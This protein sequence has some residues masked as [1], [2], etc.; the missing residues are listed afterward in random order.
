MEERIIKGRPSKQAPQRRI[1][2]AKTGYDPLT[3]SPC[4]VEDS[5]WITNTPP[6]SPHHPTP[7][8][9]E[10]NHWDFGLLDFYFPGGENIC[11]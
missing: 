10:V 6:P 2:G 8:G 9:V 3:Y 7:P 1:C 11:I 4:V 5:V